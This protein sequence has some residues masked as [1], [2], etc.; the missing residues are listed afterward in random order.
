MADN[1]RQSTVSG[2]LWAQDE[3]GSL[4][5]SPDGKF[6]LPCWYPTSVWMVDDQRAM[7]SGL[8]FA[9]PDR[10]PY[11]LFVDPARAV[12][13]ALREQM[14]HQSIH[15]T[16]IAVDVDDS[17]GAPRE[18]VSVDRSAILRAVSNPD[19]FSELS[20]LIL[21]YGMP[22]MTGLDL[23]S[24]IDGVRARRVLFT[25]HGQS[26]DRDPLAL[27]AFNSG[28]IQ[29]YLVKG[30]VVD[31]KSDEETA[32][33]V[34]AVI[35]EMQFEYLHERMRYMSQ[36]LE[37]VTPSFHQDPVFVQHFRQ[38]LIQHHAVEYYFLEDPA[39][40]L[41]LDEE[42]QAARVVVLD[43]RALSEWA[44]KAEISGA[45][46]DV[47]EGLRA[48]KRVPSVGQGTDTRHYTAD[49][50]RGLTVN[51]QRLEAAKTYYVGVTAATDLL[52]GTNVASYADFLTLQTG[53][54]EGDG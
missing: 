3:Q 45:P 22:K 52:S 16:A 13:E 44:A 28:H 27:K 39:G 46:A 8:S 15:D 41:M 14:S 50:W 20:C 33:E 40:F 17:G 4:G 31:N 34:F 6:M 23:L 53:D 49:M 2:E 10:F 47:V 18:T 35:D 26:S 43:E 11:R 37:I 24:R 38:M 51:A 42:G 5:M 9:F 30:N 19:R 32:N 1:K 36:T 25:G 12:D 7:L 21:D 54:I 48:R 29:R